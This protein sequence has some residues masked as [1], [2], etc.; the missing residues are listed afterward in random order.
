MKR[1][2]PREDLVHY[3]HKVYHKGW[4]ANHDGNLTIRLAADRILST[5]TALSKGD[6]TAND[7]IVV[8]RK[9]TKVSGHRGAF[10]ELALH[11]AA[12]EARADA[13]AVLHAHPPYATALGVAGLDL[14]R[15][16]IAEA[17]VSLGDC[18]PLI[19]FSLPK[20]PPWTG[21][22]ARAIVHYDALLLQ[23]HG[24]I[25][26][27]DDLEQ[28]FL[29]MELVEHLAR[30]VHHSMAFG[31]PS[32]LAP[33]TLPHLLAARTKAGL[34]PEARGLAAPP[35]TAAAATAAATPTTHTPPD[36]VAQLVL[37][38]LRRLQQGH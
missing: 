12:Y 18:V 2:D 4:V 27:G 7:L 17:V 3:A 20:T 21:D 24:V 25:T 35:H 1:T 36:R 6:V 10:S 33:D 37:E 38:E 23:N 13:R 9:G 31:G 14:A 30:I 26:C 16:I 8:D 11:L 34:G 22:V 28:A 29:R 5:P 19:P 32:Y 15:P